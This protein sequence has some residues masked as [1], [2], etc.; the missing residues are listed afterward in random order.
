[1]KNENLTLKHNNGAYNVGLVVKNDVMPHKRDFI[2][3]LYREWADPG[4]SVNLIGCT[5]SGRFFAIFNMVMEP[6]KC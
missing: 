1:M 5:R 2:F 4:H 6:A 3:I